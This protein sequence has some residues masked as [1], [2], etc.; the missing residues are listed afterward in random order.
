MATPFGRTMRAL[1]ADS[2]RPAWWTWA[3]SLLLAIAWLG[4][5]IAGRVTVYEVSQQA[6]VETQAAAHPVAALQGGALVASHMALG[7]AVH[8][9]D[10]LLELDA[11]SA[12]LR[13]REESQRL[14]ALPARRAALKAE[15]ESLQSAGRHELQ[16]TEAAVMSAQ[17]R[18]G[19]VAA[20]LEYSQEYERR[21]AGE[22]HGGG[23]AEVDLLRARSESRRQRATSEAL[24]AEA[25]RLAQD[26]QAREGQAHS[27]IDALRGQL[28]AL[29]SE[30]ATLA[31]SVARLGAEIDRLRVRAPVDGIVGDVAALHPGAWVAEG[32][33]VGTVLPS[34]GLQIV[35][36][37][38]PARA[39]G[40][41]QPGQRARLR[42]DGFPW[43]QHGSLAA[44][45][46]RV[47]AEA[48][49]QHLRVEL[50]L[51]PDAGAHQP[52]LQHGLSGTVE[53]ALE[54]VAPAVLLLRSMGQRLGGTQA[55]GTTLASAPP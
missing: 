46:Q 28:V 48:H 16:A 31:T 43:A 22:V 55:T 25:R 51:E 40:R 1:A 38:M 8:A 49:D 50:V 3:V 20:Q 19:E 4:W 37:F 11:R 12:T 42:L 36:E 24:Q 21:L 15:I 47:A 39:L 53:V 52:T 17:A 6:H 13:L 14:T 33:H 45:V 10:I 54:D 26:A 35:A 41:L 23:I 9:G 2:G 5:F 18:A 30:S 44:R 29:D 27:R 34:G 7:R 32:Q